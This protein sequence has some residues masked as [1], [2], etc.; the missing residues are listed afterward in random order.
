MIKLFSVKKK[1]NI[2][3]NIKE[4]FKKDSKRRERA[5]RHDDQ[6]KNLYSPILGS[7]SG[8]K[9]NTNKEIK[10]PKTYINPTFFSPE[11]EERKLELI[12]EVKDICKDN[13]KPNKKIF[14]NFEFP[15]N[16]FYFLY[17]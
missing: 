4:F 11:K 1:T 17:T 7:I 16:I 3:I 8:I 10:E 6:S 14:F 13:K 5:F 15:L 2:N 12:K 9:K